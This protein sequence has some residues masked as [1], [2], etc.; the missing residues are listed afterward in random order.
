MNALA[1]RIAV[2]IDA[3]NASAAHAAAIFEEVAKH[4]EANIRRIYGDFSGTRLRSWVDQILPL[5][6][7]ARF[8][9]I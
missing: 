4:R 6:I 9:R 5:A 7:T 1:S 8:E 3:D 2:L